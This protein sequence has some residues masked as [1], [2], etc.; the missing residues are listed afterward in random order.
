MSIEDWWND[1]HKGKSNFGQRRLSQCHLV[2]HKSQMEEDEAEPGTNR[3]NHNMAPLNQ[4]TLYSKHTDSVR[5]LQKTV[6]I[7]IRK[8]NRYMPYSE[9]MDVYCNNHAEHVRVNAMC[10]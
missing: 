1:T 9:T 7:T 6:S 5:T 2:K 4:I 8:T 3:L 10:R